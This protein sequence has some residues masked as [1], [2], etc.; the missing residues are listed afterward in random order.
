MATQIESPVAAV[1]RAP[2]LPILGSGDFTFTPVPHWPDLP[3]GMELG[4]VAAVAVDD[5]DQVY[6]FNRGPHPMIV[7]TS[8]GAFLRSWGEGTFKNPHGLHFGHDGFLYC[9]D[10]GDHTV[11]KCTPDGRVHMT[12]GVPGQPAPF[13]SGQPF[14]RCCHTAL[15]PTGEI[16]VADG[17]GNAQIHKYAPDGRHLFSWG[18]PGTDP[19]QFNL[20][21]NI[22][23]D[24]DGWVYVAD[25]EN[26]RIQIFDANGRYEAQIGNLHRASALALIGSTCP[27]CVVGEIG[28][29]MNVN[30]RFPN[31][32]PRISIMRT[33]GTLVARL[34]VAPAAGQAPGQFISPHGIALD[35]H[36][37]IYVGEVS[38]RAWLSLFPGEDLPQPL[39]RVQK[40]R[41]TAA[42]A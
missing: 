6:L 19:G 4:D 41:R 39:R 1:D 16:Y 36:G 38:S 30:R 13:M 29:Y 31:L 35:S 42:P 11:R 8:E 22:C 28:P 17:Y 34:G 15:S 5:R 20:P 40:L 33:D 25:R 2:A 12:L 9:T 26:H 10:E 37:D 7:T 3:P 23:C 21:H 18:A 14:C 24:A 27:L 32:G